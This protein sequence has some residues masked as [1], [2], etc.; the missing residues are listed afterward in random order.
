MYNRQQQRMMLVNSLNTYGYIS[1]RMV[2]LTRI[3][4]FLSLIFMSDLSNHAIASI[5]P[6]RLQHL[7]LLV[8]VST[9]DERVLIDENNFISAV[10]SDTT[11]S[12]ASQL[13]ACSSGR[14]PTFVPYHKNGT[15]GAEILN[16]ELP[17]P[18]AVYNRSSIVLAAITSVERQLRIDEDLSE[19]VNFVIFC[20]P[21]GLSGPTF[22][23]SSALNSFWIVARPSACTNPSILLHEFGHLYGLKH[24]R[25]GVEE[26]GDETSIMG[27]TSSKRNRCFNGYNFWKLGWFNNDFAKEVTIPSNPAISV[28]VKLATFVDLSSLQPERDWI[29]LLKVNDLYVV[30]NR[31]K[32][33]NNETGEYPNKVTIVR[34]LDT[35]ESTLVAGLTEKY[36]SNVYRFTSNESQRVTIQVC[37][38]IYENLASAEH[39]TVAVGIDDFPCNA[40][41]AKLISSHPTESPSRTTIAYSASETPAPSPI[42]K[43]GEDNLASDGT[44]IETIVLLDTS[45]PSKGPVKTQQSSFPTPSKTTET[46]PTTTPSTIV[47]RHRTSVPTTNVVHIPSPIASKSNSNEYIDHTTTQSPFPP[48]RTQPQN[49]N[50]TARNNQYAHHSILLHITISIIVFAFVS[51]AI[52]CYMRRRNKPRIDQNQTHTLPAIHDK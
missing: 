16:V 2:K 23:A 51:L 33:F 13:K 30:Y 52:L 43:S 12:V 50:D 3:S 27:L 18:A 22:L 38:H 48:I 25:Q 42:P 19:V 4:F 31:Q 21:T 41:K 39:Y 26:Y 24:A 5:V 11:Y 36:G 7:G 9:V 20:V 17:F 34:E 35:E 1:G 15:F 47:K 44:Y 49:S 14:A 32:M 40:T 37:D 6:Q 8:T 10:Y 45:S 28:I 46:K 29:V